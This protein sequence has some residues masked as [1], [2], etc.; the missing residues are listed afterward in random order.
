M[1]HLESVTSKNNKWY[2]YLLVVIGA[3]VIANMITSIPFI[4]I[5]AYYFFKNGMDMEILP[6]IVSN[7]F[8]GIDKNLFLFVNM[9]VF[10]VLLLSAIFLIKMLHR[11]KWKEVINGTNR[12]RWSRFFFSFLIYG[13]ITT[14]LFAVFYFIKPDNYVFQF[15]PSRFFIL[16]VIAV[17]FIPIQ[18]STEEFLFRGYFAQGIASW[19]KSRWWALIIPSVLFG[20][21]HIINPEIK[22]FGFF[23]MMPQYIFVGLILGIMSILDDGIELAM[24]AHTANNM[25]AALFVTFESSALQTDALFRAKEV[26]PSEDF[27]TIIIVG[28]VIL[29]IFAVKYKWNFRVL[30]QKVVLKEESVL[31]E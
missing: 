17:L 13:L 19:T 15:D 25:F 10:V 30:N 28:V 4:I 27:L 26:N 6:D 2:F 5:I 23:V 12:V 18:S 7:N 29:A 22:E 20:L 24:G 31:Q 1:K 9:F 8:S 16:L 14:I 3:F 21:M 11:R